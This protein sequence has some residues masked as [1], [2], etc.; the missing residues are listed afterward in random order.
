MNRLKRLERVAY[1]TPIDWSRLVGGR[2]FPHVEL[3]RPGFHT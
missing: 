1:V 2:S 3:G